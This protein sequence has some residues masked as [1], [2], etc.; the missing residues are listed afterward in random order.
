M[1]SITYSTSQAAKLIGVHKITLIRW[2]LD[3]KVR[4]PRRMEL[5][6]PALPSNQEAGQSTRIWTIRDVERV[7]KFKRGN[8]C[9]GR[10]RKPKPK[11]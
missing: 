10:G 5:P 3:G 4:E 2:L 9:K 1:K 6:G 11:R 7:R 8:Y